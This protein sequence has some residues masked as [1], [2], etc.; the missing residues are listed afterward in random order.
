VFFWI[1]IT[2]IIGSAVGS[3]LNVV[4]DRATRGQSILGRSYCDHCGKIIAPLD[5][6]PIV[7]FI[8][9]GARCR[10]CKKSLSW[11]YPL[12]EAIT[13]LLFV[14]SFLVLVFSGQLSAITL[15]YYFFLIATLL[16]VAVVD[17]KFSLIPTTLVFFASIVSL[18]YNYFLFSSEL[19]VEHVFA[20]FG[21]AIF[22]LIIVLATRGRG[23]GE[24]DIVLGFLIGMVLGYGGTFAAM[25][26]A[27]LLGA[28]VSIFLIVLGRKKFGQTIP[29]APFLIGGFLVSLF[30]QNEIINW[31]LAMLY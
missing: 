2:F 12:V 9:L 20:A 26:L 6:V 8:A 4:I 1:L 16:V 18:F 17:L 10:W 27:F 13:S 25:F 7:S 23:M 5:L 21:A 31:Y 22:F 30:W 3:F 11:Q 19:F 28:I 14:L 24:G 29:F 15:V